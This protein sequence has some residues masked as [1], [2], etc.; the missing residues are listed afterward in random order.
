MT[1]MPTFEQL[2]EHPPEVAFPFYGIAGRMFRL[3]DNVYVATYDVGWDEDA[4]T[5]NAKGEKILTEDHRWRAQT[6]RF[7]CRIEEQPVPFL[8]DREFRLF[9]S[10]GRRI[11]EARLLKRVKALL[12]HEPLGYVHLKT[13]RN[14]PSHTL[15]L[16][17]GHLFSGF[18][19][20][21]V[22]PERK[23][24]RWVIA[25]LDHDVP[26]WRAPQGQRWDFHDA[27]P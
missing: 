18:A 11:K 26:E 13:Y 24:W 10:S 2:A 25:G 17:P 5:T 19:L 22:G 14:V 21:D 9:D 20:V 7:A 4:I 23:G 3:G 1:R 15:G 12:R 8:H 6:V 16:G 27:R